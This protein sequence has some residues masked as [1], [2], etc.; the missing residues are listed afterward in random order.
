MTS[1]NGDTMNKGT[2]KWFNPDKGYGFITTDN[3]KE[4][5]V[6]YSAI[7]SNGYRT[8]QEG[9]KVSFD[10]VNGKQGQQAKNVMIL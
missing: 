8:L 10:I 5:F 3:A 1:R 4:I 7:Q 9:T 6:H 2:V